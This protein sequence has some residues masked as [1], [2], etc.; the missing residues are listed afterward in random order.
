MTPLKHARYSPGGQQ[1]EGG[2]GG[3]LEGNST[4]GDVD[5]AVGAGVA[6]VAAILARGTVWHRIYN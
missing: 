2:A 5:G 4:G 3:P 6:A 1:G